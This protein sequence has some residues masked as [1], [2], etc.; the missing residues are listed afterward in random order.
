MDGGP[1]KWKE[2]RF[3][4]NDH[5]LRGTPAADPDSTA[6]WQQDIFQNQQLNRL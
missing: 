1:E 3:D 2:F 4:D 6:E 5:E